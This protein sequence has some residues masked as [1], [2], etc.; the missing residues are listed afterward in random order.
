MATENTLTF[1]MDSF[2]PDKR[3]WPSKQ[4]QFYNS[5]VSIQSIEIDEEKNEMKATYHNSDERKSTIIV[6]GTDE[7]ARHRIESIVATKAFVEPF[8][9]QGLFN[10]ISKR[11]KY[12][13]T[14]SLNSK[15]RYPYLTTSV[16]AILLTC[17]TVYGIDLMSVFRI[18]S[19]AFFLFGVVCSWIFFSNL[20]KGYAYYRYN[21]D[22]KLEDF[23][24]DIENPFA[25]SAEEI[26]LRNSI[27]N[28]MVL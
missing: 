5:V 11:E 4:A 28:A 9:L 20:L 13:L 14:S 25:R 22:C 26:K 10:Y 16:I 1:L 3:P 6:K 18:T 15:K 8:K 27:N 24:A 12:I 7:Y 17:L 19:I 23:F 21:E 2:F